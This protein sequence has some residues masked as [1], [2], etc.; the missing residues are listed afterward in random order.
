[1]TKWAVFMPS[2]VPVVQALLVVDM[3][4]T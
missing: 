4:A 2:A 1:M 3:M